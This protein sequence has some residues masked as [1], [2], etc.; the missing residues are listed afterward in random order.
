M[1][2]LLVGIAGGIVGGLFGMPQ[3]GFLAGSLIGGMLF[4]AKG[5]NSQGPRLD[6]LSVTSSAYGASIYIVY[7]TV[8]TA[9]NVIWSLKLREKKKKQKQGGKGGMGGGSSTTTYSYFW[10]GAVGLC[11][12]PIDDVLRIWADSKLVFDKQ[13]PNAVTTKK[14]KLNFRVYYGDEVQVPDAAMEAD[15]GAANAVAHRG[16]A[17]VLFDDIPVEDYGNRPPSWSFEVVA[18]TQSESSVEGVHGV[19]NLAASPVGAPFVGVLLPDFQR[20]RFYTFRGDVANGGIRMYNSVTYQEVLARPDEEVFSP[21]STFNVSSADGQVCIDNDGY[22]YAA[23]GGGANSTEMAKIDGNS[24]L[25]V[26]RGGA[27]SSNLNPTL[28]LIQPVCMVAVQAFTATGQAQ[29]I[30]SCSFIS[31]A[32]RGIQL[33]SA[34]GAFD[35]LAVA[36]LDERY[37]LACQG[38][39]ETGKAVAYI[40]GRWQYGPQQPDP[41]GIYK[42]EASL[43]AELN[44]DP[45]TL[46]NSSVILTKI[47]TV[48]PAD[49]VSWWT[50]FSNMPGLFFDTKEGRLYFYVQGGR[51]NS[52]HELL[53]VRYNP[54]T[55]EVERTYPIDV[56]ISNFAC[57][58]R[59]RVDN[60]TISL[61]GGPNLSGLES[62]QTINLTTGDSKTVAGWDA[63]LHV[64][65]GGQVYD[66]ASQTIIAVGNTSLTS[67]EDTIVIQ[68][69]RHSSGSLTLGDIVADVCN[70][71][72]LEDAD[73]DVTELTDEV[74]GYILNQQMTGRAAIEPLALAYHFDGVESDYL[75]KFPKRGRSSALTITQPKLAFLDAER[76]QVLKET[77]IQEVELPERISVVYM[78]KARD[79]EQST[80]TSKRVSNPTPAMYS[81]NQV[82]NTF[83]IVFIDEEAKRLAE[84]LLFTSWT[85]RVLPEFNIGWQYLKLDPVDAITITLDS[86]VT[87]GIRLTEI[88]VGADWTM[89]MKAVS[90]K[91]TTYSSTVVS[92]GGLNFPQ[93]VPLGPTHTI[94]FLF[95]IPLL[96]DQ[97]DT[98]GN[99]SRLYTAGGGYGEGVWP[100]ERIE[101][102]ADG[103]F[104]DTVA[105]ILTESPWGS[106]LA[107][108]GTPVD[109]FVTDE[110]NT[111]TVFMTTGGDDLVS[112]S[113][114][115]MLNGANPA[116]ILN[117]T[118]GV[119]EIVGYRDVTLNA[120]GS[121]TLSGILRGQRGTDVYTSTHAAGEFFIIPSVDTVESFLVGLNELNST[122]YYKGVPYGETFED[123]PLITLSATGRDL[124]PYAPW[125]QAAVTA[126]ADITISWER[127]TRIG[128]ALKDLSPTVPLAEATEAYEIDIYDGS[129]IKR[130]LTSATTSVTYTGAQI[131]ADFGSPPATLKFAV[132]QM[133]AAVG[134]GFAHIKTVDVAP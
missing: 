131:T 32:G 52:T 24:L 9:G 60:A 92:N 86:G 44:V 4:P 113:Q 74:H 64:S 126:G 72:G 88:D 108:L 43:G 65:G 105:Q 59:S 2:Q 120:N 114:V 83:P 31:G 18:N 99:V 51:H 91:S 95:D 13:N 67:D 69:G 70:R 109:P 7:G 8:R 50:N 116:I 130:T 25:E 132:Y 46:T 128:G 87:Y 20:K 5:A 11:E 76:G 22:I 107:V 90:E 66:S 98:G 16:M 6:N 55:A 33:L 47:G 17:Y 89:Q 112:V 57:C 111:I 35:I 15:V 12:G 100:G 1:G 26:G 38:E 102:S 123:S 94:T 36:P 63:V 119:A 133:S 34:D 79:Y 58:S 121:Y 81:R 21:D 127:R 106:M 122:R 62:V 134:R 71:C 125:K 129:T 48:S 23:I 84:T 45:V 103:S 30:L 96:R 39:T 124:K 53:L 93:Q 117:A 104:Y 41:L 101:H 28:G 68:T 42:V 78:D 110:V 27:S 73:I 54:V 10:T 56:T 118:T 80:Q 82:S 97:D 77:R 19:H 3:L 37:G 61:L 115:E 75:L 29:Y 14:K 85:E 49:V 40:V